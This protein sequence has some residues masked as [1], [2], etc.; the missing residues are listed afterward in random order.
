MPTDQTLFSEPI[1]RPVVSVV[2]VNWQTT[3]HLKELLTSI[4]RQDY[5]GQI[6]I[7][8]IN[9][10]D[11][12]F[13]PG[14]FA[15]FEIDSIIETGK[16]IGFAAGCNIGI[17]AS[18]GEFILLCN[19]DVI[20]GVN[21]VNTAVEL[22]T[23]S[24]HELGWVCGKTLDPL[25]PIIIAGCG[26]ELMRDRT[27]RERGAGEID[28][29]K[30]NK[31]ER[32]FG[33]SAACAMYRRSA[34]D[35]VAFEHEYFD[36]D[37][38]AYGE[39][40]DLDWRL[41][42]HG[43]Y[44]LYE[45]NLLAYH[46]KH[47]SG[48]RAQSWIRKTAEKNRWL[49][50][51]KNDNVIDFILDLPG[52]L[53]W[54]F[55]HFLQVLF[56]PVLW[57]SFIDVYRNIPRIISWRRFEFAL[58][59][60]SVRNL[61]SKRFFFELII[62]AMNRLFTTRPRKIEKTDK[63]KETIIPTEILEI[64]KSLCKS[65][66]KPFLDESKR[67][68]LTIKYK[69]NADFLPAVSIIILNWNGLRQTVRCLDTLREQNYPHFEVIIVDN[70]SE[71]KEAETIK[72]HYP[73]IKMIELPYNTGFAVGV[74]VGIF[75]A[76]G[77]F[78]VLMNNDIEPTNNCLS[79]LVEHYLVS[80]AVVVNGNLENRETNDALG[81]LGHI[82]RDALDITPWCHYPSGGLCLLDLRWLRFEQ[83]IK[84][85][86][87]LAGLLEPTF[88]A[89]GEDVDLGWRIQRAGGRI[90]KSFRAKAKHVGSASAKKFPCWKLRFLHNRARILN[91]LINYPSACIAVVF[92][93]LII[94]WILTKLIGIFHYPILAGSIACDWWFVSNTRKVF[95]L[96]QK[97]QNEENSAS[98][99]WRW[100]S[101]KLHNYLGPLNW[102][103]VLWLKLW[104][105]RT[106]EIDIE[107]EDN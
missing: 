65:R 99:I 69:E 81:I 41:N 22:F 13:I 24:D 77:D 23:S 102:L 16:N 93:F 7:V 70:G 9:N 105:I 17:A 72:M 101:G 67:A 62:K 31:T 64:G 26:H 86:E 49:M 74:E 30:Y 95:N 36:E 32:V 3:D 57:F 19:P 107:V 100:I 51:I 39:D 34:L 4:R 79:E 18:K 6:E 106:C 42:R 61:M 68:E 54:E 73:A 85:R 21:Y 44:C 15:E 92:P 63:H 20:L 56:D 75:A 50:I 8:I 76:T 98:N 46:H 40:I 37:F 12:K 47:A 103:S 78:L 10:G 2:T 55:L 80:D 5:D 66:F 88:F 38:F 53:A 83:L 94:E 35:N 90:S 71:N 29:G 58:P 89:Y 84:P 48:G 91:I 45:P 27:A 11:N 43:F 28:K 87:Q 97:R 25:Q 33:A 14:H 104:G 82:I 96:R 60:P 1:K 52:I 59:E